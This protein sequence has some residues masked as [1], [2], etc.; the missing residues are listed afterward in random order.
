MADA[1]ASTVIGKDSTFK[2]EF[3]TEGSA[4]VLG[5]VEGTITAKGVLE[6][7]E[8]G[9][10]N[11]TITAERLTI[12]GRVEGSVTVRNSLNL[13]SKGALIGDL[14]ANAV[15]IAEG[16]TLVGHCRVGPE[17]LKQ[18][19]GA[20]AAEPKAQGQQASRR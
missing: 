15:T 4:K 1:S 9:R 10:C 13:S 5:T 14:V 8:G 6:I 12:D 16:A 19:S 20:Q 17:A 3:T 7:P 18:G 11:A 2:G